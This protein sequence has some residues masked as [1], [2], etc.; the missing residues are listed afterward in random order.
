MSLLD[1]TVASAVPHLPRSLVGQVAK[2]YISGE[3]L[4]SAF[5][6]TRE[7]NGLGITTTLDVLG[8]NVRD[9]SQVDGTADLYRRILT[10][11]REQRLD[12]NV[13]VKLTSLGLSLDRDRCAGLVRD[14]V[15]RAHD[16]DLFVRIDMED[17]STTDDTLAIFRDIHRS[18]DNLGV[19]LQARLK[20][21]ERD[22]RELAEMGARVRI[23]KGIYREP[24]SI[25]YQD[26]AEI[27]HSFLRITE[28]LLAHGCHVG[29]ATHDAALVEGSYRILEK[30]GGCSGGYEFQMLYGVTEGLRGTIVAAG[31]PLRVYV[32]FGREWYD[33]SIR[34]LRENP[35]IAGH[36]FRAMIGLGG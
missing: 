12:G 17:S 18:R 28:H 15:D 33:Y 5:R 1:R 26:G 10:G 19:V 13:S 16:L 11:L 3:D 36:V 27:N 34:R 25:A 31:H 23:C 32:P 7:L 6:V 22:A 2:R 30:L 24:P 35:Q 21:S 20:R 14:L 4:D 29:I 8:E 9:W